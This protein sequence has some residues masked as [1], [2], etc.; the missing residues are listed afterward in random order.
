LKWIIWVIIDQ[1]ITFTFTF[2]RPI[3]K[4]RIIVPDNEISLSTS[5]VTP[6]S[7]ITFKGSPRPIPPSVLPEK[8]KSQL[9][10]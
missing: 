10:S 1:V 6:L 3:R 9:G 8:N 7:G 4:V 5:L 2:N